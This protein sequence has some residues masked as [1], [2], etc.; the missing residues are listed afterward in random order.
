MSTDLPAAFAV[1]QC[2]TFYFSTRS[3]TNLQKI[4]AEITTVVVVS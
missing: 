1:I 3:E 4:V 2:V